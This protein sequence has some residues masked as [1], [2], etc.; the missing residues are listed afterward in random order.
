M[1]GRDC[2]VGWGLL[3]TL[4]SPSSPNQFCTPPPHLLPESFPFLIP[5]INQ[6]VLQ[7]VFS[8]VPSFTKTS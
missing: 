7:R 4:G 3:G 2:S 5:R 6:F 1:G 8:D